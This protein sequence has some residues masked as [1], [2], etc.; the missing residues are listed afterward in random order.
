MGLCV[1]TDKQCVA[2]PASSS[3]S[4]AWGMGHRGRRG[5][6]L[7]FPSC[8]GRG[9]GQAKSL[10]YHHLAQRRHRP[11]N[12]PVPLPPDGADIQQVGRASGL[13]AL[14]ENHA[15]EV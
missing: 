1:M 8:A 15:A 2:A 11:S 3:G 5:S 14:P 6:L 9:L 7:P 13:C 12:T 4:Q 10:E